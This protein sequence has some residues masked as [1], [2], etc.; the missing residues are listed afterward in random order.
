MTFQIHGVGAS[1]LAAGDEKNAAQHIHL[2]TGGIL[3]SCFR[4]MLGFATVPDVWVDPVGF[5]PSKL[6]GS[7]RKGTR[8]F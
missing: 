4:R 3:Q 6:T 8:T 2:W 1:I 7:T 5:G